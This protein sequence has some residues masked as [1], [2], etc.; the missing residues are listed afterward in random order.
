[1]FPS[2]PNDPHDQRLLAAV[3]PP[4]WV[5]PTPAARYNLVV[6]GGGTAGLVAAAGATGLGA[7]VALV[8]RA[9]LGGDCLNYGCVPSKTLIRAA[10]AVADVREADQFGVIAHCGA[11]VDFGAVMERV[12]R[13]RA[14]IAPHD[15]AQRMKSLGV[16]VF[17]G[18]GRFTGATT[19]EVA[20]AKLRFAKAVVATGA[21]AAVPAIPGLAEAGFLTNET[22]WSLTEL[23]RRLAIIGGGPIGSELAQAFARLGAQVTLIHSRAHLL[24]RED[25]DAA[26]LVQAALVRDGVELLL[27]TKPAR[28]TVEGGEKLIWLETGHVAADAILVAAGRQ[29][30]VEGLG[31]EAAGIAFDLQTGVQ[32]DDHLRTTNRRVFASGDVCSRFKF[33]HAA[34]FMSRLVLQNALF[35]GRKRVSALTIPWATYTSPE[36]AHVGLSERTAAEQG[37]AVTKFVRELKDV[38]RARTDGE[39]EG[40]VKILVA[41]GSDRIVGATIVARHAGE[42]IGEVA[43]AMAGGVGLGRLASVIHPYPTQAEAIRQCGDAYNRTRLTPTI[44]AMFGRWLKWQ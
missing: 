9:L 21:R 38:D 41:A 12:R 27:G 31:L 42:L 30:N 3:H 20:G 2:L 6:L 15:G 24:D 8:E 34:D 7:K 19:V 39:T 18:E 10:R 36:V 35:L 32:V 44:K 13:L 5:N 29:P 37:V 43:V 28:V 25:D 14:D 1:M 23:P 22:V 17:L 11:T 16:D 4:G 33:T 26:A 40:F